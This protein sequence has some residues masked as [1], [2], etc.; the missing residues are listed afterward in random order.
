MVHRREI[1]DSEMLR[2]VILRLE[3]ENIV[4]EAICFQMEREMGLL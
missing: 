1:I 4:E 3:T 2:K